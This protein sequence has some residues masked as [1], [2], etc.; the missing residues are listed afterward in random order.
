MIQE[1]NILMTIW[2]NSTPY[3]NILYNETEIAAIFS[4]APYAIYKLGDKVPRHK[5]LTTDTTGRT[6]EL[7]FYNPHEI[8]HW[9]EDNKD[10]KE[11]MMFWK[12]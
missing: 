9:V 12:Q 7:Y 1:G 10:S 11:A 6:V 2:I 8:I 4:V 3:P 5:L